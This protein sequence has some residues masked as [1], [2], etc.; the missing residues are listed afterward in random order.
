MAAK[1][2]VKRSEIEYLVSVVED[3]L[4]KGNEALKVYIETGQGYD[5]LQIHSHN[6]QQARGALDVEL[7]EQVGN[8]NS[9]CR[10]AREEKVREAMSTEERIE[11]NIKAL[12]Y[13]I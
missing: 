10:M 12:G 5:K 6:I 11:D 9:M 13:K 8:F 4:K 7:G 1:S 2:K 3:L